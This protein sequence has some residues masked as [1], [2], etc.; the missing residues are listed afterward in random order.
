MLGHLSC[1]IKTEGD[2][3]LY[4]VKCRKC[5]RSAE[6][7]MSYKTYQTTQKCRC[8]ENDW[9]RLPSAPNFK[10]LGGTERFYDKGEKK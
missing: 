5:G 3:P 7:L 1:W 8:G 10:V 6:V 4:R 2:V 9:Q